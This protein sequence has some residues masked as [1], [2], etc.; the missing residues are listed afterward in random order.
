M[1]KKG[2]YNER[3]NVGEELILR[4]FKSWRGKLLGGPAQVPI[5][6]S[7]RS[8][9]ECVNSNYFEKIKTRTDDGQDPSPKT[10]SLS[11][12]RR[13]IHRRRRNYC[14]HYRHNYD[15]L[16]QSGFVVA[17]RMRT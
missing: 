9:K 6:K 1:T 16:Q 17:Q 5:T 10:T 13:R 8:Q 15:Q 12:S 7:P 3:V 14:Q 11:R 4:Q 2:K